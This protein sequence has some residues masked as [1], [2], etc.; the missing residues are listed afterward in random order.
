LERK[1]D[2]ITLM[3][4]EMDSGE[5]GDVLRAR[6]LA[7][8]AEAIFTLWHGAFGENMED[9]GDLRVVVIRAEIY[10]TVDVHLKIPLRRT[11]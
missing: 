11:P 7:T 8:L 6:H 5:K 2:S 9:R 3:T 10:L 1:G 4:F